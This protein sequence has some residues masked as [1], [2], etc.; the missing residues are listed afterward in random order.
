MKAGLS[1]G[2]FLTTGG[3]VKI[4]ELPNGTGLYLFKK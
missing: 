2:K 3:A 1:S 4:G